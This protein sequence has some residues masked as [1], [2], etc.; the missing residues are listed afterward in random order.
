MNVDEQR[1]HIHARKNARTRAHTQDV[2]ISEGI[3]AVLYSDTRVLHLLFFSRKVEML[4]DLSEAV[5][6]SL[7]ETISS[8][9]HLEWSSS[10]C[11]RRSWALH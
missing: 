8:L 6:T 11:L 9:G 3:A 4:K 5:L 2:I 7:C 1:E 10:P